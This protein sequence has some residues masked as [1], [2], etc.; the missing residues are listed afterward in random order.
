MDKIR[1]GTRGSPLALAQA[2][3]V[4]NRLIVNKKTLVANDV[5]IVPIKT[6]GD[7]ILDR[8]LF[9]EG[10]KGLFTKEIEE[11]LLAGKVDLA[12]HSTK[13]M[14]AGLPDGL[15]LCAFLERE[16][17]R[18]ALI[19]RNGPNLANLPEGAVI[20]TSSLRRQAQIL[21]F[22]PDLRPMPIRGNVETRLQKISNGD[23]AATILAVAGLKRLGLQTRIT[24]TLSFD[25]I[26]PAPGQGAI[27][28]QA[29][30]ND[31]K[32]LALLAPLNHQ[33][34]MLAIA[35]ERAVVETLGASCRMPLA[36]Y[37]AIED[38]KVRLRAALFRVDGLESW[39]A[40]DS[41]TAKDAAALGRKL[42][43][44]LLSK[45][46]PQVLEQFA[47]NRG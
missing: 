34:T 1:I 30:E 23:V 3:E 9:E 35:A 42:G 18:D 5:E 43:K 11:H 21:R 36:A 41:V 44:E 47:I 8:S 27:C 13:D 32:T 25:E 20:G 37:A 10:G 26:L 46:D 15:V 12:V 31:E 38:N 17:P 14:P 6:T 40:E 22:R 24:A 45:A 28:L 39:V 29:R 2:H 16:D 4:K 7:K 19:C 33:P